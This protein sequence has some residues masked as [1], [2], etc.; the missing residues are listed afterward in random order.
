MI[1][2]VPIGALILVLIPWMVITGA[3]NPES[4]SYG[5]EF[6]YGNFYLL[7]SIPVGLLGVLTFSFLTRW[8]TKFVQR[9]MQR[10]G[11]P[12]LLRVSYP[13]ALFGEISTAT[14][15]GS[16]LMHVLYYIDIQPS[17][18]TRME[19]EEKSLIREYY[20]RCWLQGASPWPGWVSMLE[21]ACV[22]WLI[23]MIPAIIIEFAKHP[24]YGGHGFMPHHIPYLMI[25]CICAFI[26]EVQHYARRCAFWG[27]TIQQADTLLDDA[28]TI[29]S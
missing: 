14:S 9:N 21:A 2:V 15:A 17:R 5:Q 7:C 3:M 29:T 18:Y 23:F 11:F 25:S 27:A 12:E 19:P 26:S 13:G 6:R 1:I 4:V 22:A 10:V 24:E 20:D 8:L 16:R 28:E